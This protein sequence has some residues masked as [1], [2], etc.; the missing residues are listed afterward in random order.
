MRSL[1]FPAPPAVLTALPISGLPTDAFFFAG[2]LPAREGARRTR[3]EELAAIPGSLVFFES[4]GRAGEALRD[5]ADL[6]GARPAALARELTKMHE[7]V[8]RGSLAELAA[9][10]AATDP[11]GEV[12]IVVGPPGEATLTDED[13]EVSARDGA[14]ALQRAR[15]GQGRGRCA[16]GAEGSC[17]RH[18]AQGE[19]AWDSA[20]EQAYTD[21]RRA[22]YRLG[23]WSEWMA[24][25]LLMAKGYRILRRR[26]QTPA[27]EIDLIAVRRRRLAFVE[28]KRRL[29]LE[30]A[31]ASISPRQRQRVRQGRAVV[32]WTERPL[33]AARCRLRHRVRAAEA[34]ADAYRKRPPLIFESREFLSFRAGHDCL[35]A[36]AS[37][38]AGL[39]LGA[40]LT[41]TMYQSAEDSRGIAPASRRGNG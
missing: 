19:A 9:Q 38:F 21:A 11:K 24:A 30:D 5:L 7:E 17:L 2:F 26:E 27:G 18:C 31:E 29:T 37:G 14:P 20:S 3:I 4:P 34:V 28:V 13:I 12:V 1:P 41:L 10:F 33:S 39:A 16:Q 40:A 32:A 36:G 15:C 35:N 8:V 22:R 25:L 23:R 6:L